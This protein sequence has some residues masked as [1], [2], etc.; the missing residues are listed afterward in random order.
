MFMSKIEWLNFNEEKDITKWTKV[1]ENKEIDDL[2]KEFEAIKAWKD[3]VWRQVKTLETRLLKEWDPKD[4]EYKELADKIKKLQKEVLALW[5]KWEK[6]KEELSKLLWEVEAEI[7]TFSKKE[8][9]LLSQI[10]NIDFL[11]IPQEKRL[12][13]ITK[14][15]VDS[16]DIVNG[17]IQKLDFTF[18]FDWKFNRELYLKTTA[19]QV[20]PKEVWS[21]NIWWEYYYRNGLMWEFFTKDNK[22]LVIHEWTEIEI[23]G[24]RTADDLERIS[25]SNRN[26]LN[27]Y[28]KNNPWANQYIVSEAINRWIDPKFAILAFG[29]L[30][31]NLQEEQ[32]KIVLEDAFTEFDR[33]RW[34]IE[35]SLEQQNW[36]YDENLVIWIFKKF[37][38]DN[39]ID[40]AISYWFTSD[41]VDNFIRVSNTKIDFLSIETWNI[42]DMIEK[43]AKT[44]WV[45]SKIIESILKQES[46]FNMSA[47]RFEKHIYDRQ[48]KKWT[49]QE[50]AKLLATS[51]WWF[52][53]MWFNY[54]V[55]W[56]SS[57]IDFV[58]AM[59]NPENQFDAFANFVKSNPKLHR[60]MRWENPDFQTIA[61]YYNWP[62]YRQN[63]YDNKIR[64]YF[65]A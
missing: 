7:K 49:S 22:R 35:V 21:V 14:N 10:S 11:S 38:P 15:C 18:T 24:L 33:Y 51:F 1:L 61:Y 47:T 27:E 26:K 52:Q 65:Y 5:E 63:N 64:Q 6:I 55:C 23:S 45:N 39:W 36:R 34:K 29:D 43:T 53:I 50:E 31:E 44:L 16:K 2:K 41:E 42:K 19:W 57:V 59:K 8:T 32:A 40:K 28:M 46:N 17:K 62:D 25:Q 60:A 30:V 3:Y 20:L 9:Q 37:S 56:Y 58:E 4:K 48:L 12:Q 54:K 13:Y